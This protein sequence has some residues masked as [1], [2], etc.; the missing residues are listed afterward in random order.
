MTAAIIARNYDDAREAAR[1]LSIGHDWT[2]PH[3]LG[4]AGPRFTRIVFV[5]GYSQSGITVEAVEEVQ[6]L[7]ATDAEVIHIDLEQPTFDQLIAPLLDP[8]AIDLDAPH[9]PR[10]ARK[11]RRRA[12]ALLG[13]VMLGGAVGIAGLVSAYLIGLLSWVS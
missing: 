3:E 7:A 8:D 11:D 5:D 9:T 4:N 2:Y 6:R 13:A 1:R 10:H 12:L